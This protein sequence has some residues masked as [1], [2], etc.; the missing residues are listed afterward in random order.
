MI[1]MI[2]NW[3]EKLH[4]N[5]CIKLK[6]SKIYLI[7]SHI[8]N[9]NSRAFTFLKSKRLKSTSFNILK[10]S[11]Q[12][13]IN[14]IFFFDKWSFLL[15]ESHSMSVYILIVRQSTWFLFWICHYSAR[16]VSIHPKNLFHM[17]LKKHLIALR[18]PKSSIFCAP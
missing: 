14:T 18:Q 16:S 9:Y 2:A 7:I 11:V 6:T 12:M 5:G 17:S 1:H 4:T 8:L 3:D 15:A 13:E 10:H